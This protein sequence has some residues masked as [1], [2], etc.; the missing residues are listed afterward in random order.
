[1]QINLSN[2]K[3]AA[4]NCR[5]KHNGNPG[6]CKG[7]KEQRQRWIEIDSEL[8]EGIGLLMDSRITRLSMTVLAH[9]GDSMLWFIAGAL[10]WRFG[11]GLW[12]RLG[13][14]IVI[15]T[16]ITWLC[17]TV[18]KL[19]IQRPRPEGEQKFFYLNIDANSFPSGHAVRAGG[20]TVA[21]GSILPV[22]G[23]LILVLWAL[24]V[25]FSR[26]ALGLHY[27][28][29]VVAGFVVGALAGLLLITW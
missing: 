9:S 1:M 7:M 28:S 2:L 6:W 25:C 13:E 8:T 24:C 23:V 3:F 22:C 17:T 5:N 14:R 15:I 26:V 21:L 10:M 29:D 20:L 11:L 27:V 18:L 12:S 16:A 4:G 19:F